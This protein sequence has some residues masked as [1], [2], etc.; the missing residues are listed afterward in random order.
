[1]AG[2]SPE[3]NEISGKIYRLIGNAIERP[4]CKAY[5][6][7]VRVRVSATRYRYPDITALCGTP[8]FADTRP[9][10]LLNPQ[11][12]IEVLSSS[13]REIDFID[14][15]AEYIALDS[16]TDYLIFE[17][18]QMRAFHYRPANP[19]AWTAQIYNTPEAVIALETIGVTLALADI[20]RN[21][22]L[23]APRTETSETENQTESE[24][25][26]AAL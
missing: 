10:T 18:N 23:P 26:N 12:V 1:M 3:H 9:R 13:T 2:E 25:D 4:R 14:K 7:E 5:F 6:A 24:T 8:Q 19:M 15:L 20:D 17:Q 21:I 11:I 16:V 22:A